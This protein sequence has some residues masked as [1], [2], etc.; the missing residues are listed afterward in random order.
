M[1]EDT[2]AV[3]VTA[4]FFVVMAAWIPLVKY[5]G[6]AIKSSP[7]ASDKATKAESLK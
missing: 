3:V 2:V 4:A 1:P 5:Y 7:N 6:R